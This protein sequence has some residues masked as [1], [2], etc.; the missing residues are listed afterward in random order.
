MGRFKKLVDSEE[1]LE[2]FRAQYR[3]P[4]EVGIRYCKEG[5]DLKKGE[6]ES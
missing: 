4:P 6:K 1:G 3:I 2:S 5:S